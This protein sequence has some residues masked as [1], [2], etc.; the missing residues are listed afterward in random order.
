MN[1]ITGEDILEQVTDITT[2]PQH[3]LQRLMTVINYC[4]CNSVYE[5][6]LTHE[7]LTSMN[8]GIGILQI[9]NTGRALNYKFIP[10]QQLEKGLVKTITTDV[11]PLTDKLETTFTQRIIKTYKDM[12]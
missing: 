8:I 1:K 12:F 11:N 5:S 9:E 7:P 10:S 4:I 2:I 6:K 3:S